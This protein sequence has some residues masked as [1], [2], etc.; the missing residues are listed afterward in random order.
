MHDDREEREEAEGAHRPDH[1]HD[2]GWLK[3]RENHAS[4]PLRRAI[5][6]RPFLSLL[7]I[8]PAWMVEKVGELPLHVIDAMLAVVGKVAAIRREAV[9]PLHRSSAPPASVR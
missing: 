9:V 8:E 5:T 6:S 7:S 4:P 3:G 2:P 1:E